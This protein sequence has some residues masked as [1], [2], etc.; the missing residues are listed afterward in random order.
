MATAKQV[1]D[2]EQVD[3]DSLS[4]EEVNK[5]VLRTVLDLK[6]SLPTI[7]N[8][9]TKLETVTKEHDTEIDKLKRDMLFMKQKMN[10]KEQQEKSNSLRFIGVHEEEEELADNKALVRKVYQ[11]F[12]PVWTAAKEAEFIEAVPRMT[13]VNMTCFRVGARNPP[14]SEQPSSPAKPR[15]IIVKFDNDKLRS[16]LFK[17]KREFL[18]LPGPEE[19]AMGIKYLTL[20]EDL[21]GPNLRALRGLQANDNIDKAW[22]SGG[23]VKFT[24]KSDKQAKKTVYIAKNIFAEPDEIIFDAYVA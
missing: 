19:Q 12:T 21:T 2:I 10:R 6:S 7:E 22:A 5:L 20:V 14:R 18:P 1:V 11:L 17:F 16:A 23:R 9:V 4:P 13:T 3:I 8:K 15:P 24:L